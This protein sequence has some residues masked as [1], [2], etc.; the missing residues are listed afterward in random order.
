MSS[1]FDLPETHTEFPPAFL[2][3]SACSDWLVLVPLANPAQAQVML[4]RQLN[5]LHRY[6]LA[7]SARLKLLETMR[8]TV[9]EVQRDV[10]KKFANRPLPLN[11]TEQ[12]AFDGTLAVWQAL[13]GGYLRLLDAVAAGDTTIIEQGALI[14]QRSLSVFADWEVD[15]CRGEKLPDV[16]FWRRLHKVFA[17]AEQLKLI[18]LPVRDAAR[19]GN[20]QTT[21][22]AAYAESHL[23]HSAS[24]F[25]LPSRHLDWIARWSRRW[26][27]KLTMRTDGAPTD[28]TRAA[29]LF[30]DIDSDRPAGY[31]SRD[32][33]GARWLETDEL[34]KSIKARL[35]MLSQGE[36]PKRLQL[37]EDCTQPATSLLLECFYQGW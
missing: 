34:R 36:L 1:Y 8:Q 37:G 20:E 17:L 24:P 16:N 32:V 33:P 21:A 14:A 12:A 7:N 18:S 3:V 9:I 28:G 35:V 27:N 2:T 31:I 10:A 11:P 5:L 25:E 19:H 13:L 23:L 22:L 15:L 30:V 26:C 6:T 4:L 29:P